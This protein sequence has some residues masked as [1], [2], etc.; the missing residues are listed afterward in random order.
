M[1][2]HIRAEQ[3]GCV[4][5][6]L[7]P[8]LAHPVSGAAKLGDMKLA[9]VCAPP[10]TLIN[11][12]SRCCQ[13]FLRRLN[14]TFSGASLTLIFLAPRPY[15]APLPHCSPPQS[16]LNIPESPAPRSL[17]I[18]RFSSLLPLPL[19][20]PLPPPTL[21]FLRRIRWIREASWIVCRVSEY[22][23]GSGDMWARSAAC[24][25]CGLEGRFWTFEHRP[26]SS[27]IRAPLAEVE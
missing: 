7:H 18:L 20:P 11:Q 17:A 1:R 22:R 6:Y 23:L 9:A 8:L 19:P 4:A 26:G 2:H 3:S 25:N 14:M 12:S 5:L 27:R 24:K 15:P 10:Q 13:P 21:I 16:L